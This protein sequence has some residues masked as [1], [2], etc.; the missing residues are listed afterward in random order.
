MKKIKNIILGISVALTYALSTTSVFAYDSGKE[1]DFKY[2][3]GYGTFNCVLTDEAIEFDHV[4]THNGIVIKTKDDVDVK[5]LDLKYDFE[6][7]NDPNMNSAGFNIIT[8]G[9]YAGEKNVYPHYV[10]DSNV[11]ELEEYAKEIAA[12]NE[13]EYAEVFTVD[14]VLVGELKYSGVDDCRVYMSFNSDVDIEEVVKKLNENEALTEYLTSMELNTEIKID[15]QLNEDS[16]KYLYAY[17]SGI[18][19]RTK[20][21]EIGDKIEEFTKGADIDVEFVSPMEVYVTA[22]PEI[23]FIGRDYTGDANADKYIDVRDCAY[24]ASKV[25]SSEADSLPMSADFN[26]DEKV[27]VRDAAAIANHIAKR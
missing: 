17:A 19:D 18:K 1:Y 23:D 27:N 24:I 9:H 15:E 21:F 4:S 8:F 22:E 2:D 13:I 11:S 16:E 25:A 20:Y 3:Y 14:Q 26:G 5:S 12:L 6:D 7:I 10:S